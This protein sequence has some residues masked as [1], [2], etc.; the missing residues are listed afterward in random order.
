MRA[1]DFWY[2]GYNGAADD[3]TLSAEAVGAQISVAIKTSD[4]QSD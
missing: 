3:S 1:T 2:R 4:V